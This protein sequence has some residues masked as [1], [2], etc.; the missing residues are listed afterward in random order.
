VHQCWGRVPMLLLQGTRCELSDPRL[1][2]SV[3]SALPLA[4]LC[5]LEGADRAFRVPKGRNAAAELAEPLATWAR[6]VIGR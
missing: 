2:R 1:L 5:E 3:V 4:K 6:N